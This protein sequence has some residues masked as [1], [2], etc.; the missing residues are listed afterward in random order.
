MDTADILTVYGSF[1]GGWGNAQSKRITLD[2]I[3]G[4]LDKEK[5]QKCMTKIALIFLSLT[6]LE[7]GFFLS[8]APDLHFLR[9]LSLQNCV[10][11]NTFP[12]SLRCKS[13]YKHLTSFIAQD[14]LSQ[15]S[16]SHPF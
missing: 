10:T 11:V 5:S 9:A 6:K 1:C 2:G 8:Q 7:T 16:G 12:N 15:G 14:Y 13:F 4:R 3:N